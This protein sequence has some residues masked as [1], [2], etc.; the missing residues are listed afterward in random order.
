MD[1]ID[2][3]PANTDPFAR[4]PNTVRLPPARI[5]VSKI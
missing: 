3:I 4:T 1:N 5:M 2:I